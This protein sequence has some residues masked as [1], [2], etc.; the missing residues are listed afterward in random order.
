MHNIALSCDINET[1]MTKGQ[2]WLS[3]SAAGLGKHE[4]CLPT[5]L[6]S[7]VQWYYAIAWGFSYSVN[8]CSWMSQKSSCYVTVV[9]ESQFRVAICHFFC[10]R[11]EYIKELEVQGFSHSV[12]GCL[13]SH[14]AASIFWTNTV[15][16]WYK[17]LFFRFHTVTGFYAWGG[18]HFWDSKRVCKQMLC[19]SH[20]CRGSGGMPSQ[21]IFQKIAVLR[22]NL[23]GF[24]S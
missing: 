7:A 15:H 1:L 12:N 3:S 16:R 17:A 18:T 14:A 6:L 8:G 2:P 13:W 4:L 21:K 5:T 24:G 11:L 10:S 19:K 20:P 22:L 23:V 9:L